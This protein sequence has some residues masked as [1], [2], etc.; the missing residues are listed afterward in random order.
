MLATK[1]WKKQGTT[2]FI[3]RASASPDL[4]NLV[5]NDE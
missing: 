2:E 5:E 4:D 3:S 1:I